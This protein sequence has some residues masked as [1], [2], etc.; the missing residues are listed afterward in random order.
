M[1]EIKQRELVTRDHPLRPEVLAS[2]HTLR[3]LVGVQHQIRCGET[4]ED[5][6]FKERSQ[7]GKVLPKQ[8]DSIWSRLNAL[9]L[10]SVAQMVMTNQLAILERR[11]TV[12]NVE[13]A[14]PEVIERATGEVRIL[15]GARHDLTIAYPKNDPANIKV[16]GN[17]VSS[18]VIEA[19]RKFHRA[20][21]RLRDLDPSAPLRKVAG[22]SR[23]D[24]AEALLQL[25]RSDITQGF[26]TLFDGDLPGIR[27]KPQG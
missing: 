19:V 16:F 25:G 21:V 12:E 10:G 18:E 27:P 20:S 7:L 17:G 26:R 3:R 11:R 24:A 14:Q 8:I 22:L 4:T 15:M 9:G 23:I 5:L 13:P 2:F 1:Q 6:N